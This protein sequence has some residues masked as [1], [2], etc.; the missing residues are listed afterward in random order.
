VEIVDIAITIVVNTGASVCLRVV[1]PELAAEFFV[2]H[3]SAIIEHGD[4]DRWAVILAKTLV[5]PSERAG[6]VVNPPQIAGAIGAIVG[7]S[8][9]N[10]RRWSE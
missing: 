7:L 6:Y 1:G 2:L 3:V 5:S 9:I 4:N 8:V 10:R